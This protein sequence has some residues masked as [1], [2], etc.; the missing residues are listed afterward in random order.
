MRLEPLCVGWR[1]VLDRDEGGR[2]I[3][4]VREGEYGKIIWKQDVVITIY[5]LIELKLALSGLYW[6]STNI[7]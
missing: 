7:Y 5:L 3:E 1:L 4:V 6:Q 2:L